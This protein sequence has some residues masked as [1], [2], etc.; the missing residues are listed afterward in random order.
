MCISLVSG[1]SCACSKFKICQLIPTCGCLIFWYSPWCHQSTLLYPCLSFQAGFNVWSTDSIW[2][3]F[4]GPNVI[5]RGLNF[6]S[7]RTDAT[8]FFPPS[9][10]LKFSS[11]LQMPILVYL[12]A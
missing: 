9:E 1:T 5:F 4:F 12:L 6:Y 7:R 2:V 3:L 10:T 8:F 11:V